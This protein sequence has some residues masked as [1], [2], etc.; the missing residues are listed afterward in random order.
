MMLAAVTQL[1][2]FRHKK[3]PLDEQIGIELYKNRHRAEFGLLATI[4]HLLFFVVKCFPDPK[5]HLAFSLKRR[6]SVEISPQWGCNKFLVS[7]CVLCGPGKVK[8]E[9]ANKTEAVYSP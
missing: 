1:C 3:Q 7:V 4:Y 6:A 5:I 2:P 9:I 8:L